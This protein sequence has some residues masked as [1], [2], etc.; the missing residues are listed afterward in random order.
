MINKLVVPIETGI[1]A[2][3][4]QHAHYYKLINDFVFLSKNRHIEKADA[5]KFFADVV[6]YTV[7][8]FDSEEFFMRSIDYPDI[9]DHIEQHDIFRN[10]IEKLSAELENVTNI[11]KFAEKFADVVETWFSA[12]IIMSDMKLAEYCTKNNI[13][14]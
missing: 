12:H 6:E 9:E 2:I 8:H 10:E 1:A 14:G 13:H 3:D 11:C 4:N 7:E 5:T